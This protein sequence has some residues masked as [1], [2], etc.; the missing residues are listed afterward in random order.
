MYAINLASQ[1]LYFRWE[2]EVESLA[3]E[4]GTQ[5]LAMRTY[6]LK[7]KNLRFRPV[8]LDNYYL[9]KNKTHLTM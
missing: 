7:M 2:A 4:V 9:L 8:F 6:F 3:C 5:S 1:A